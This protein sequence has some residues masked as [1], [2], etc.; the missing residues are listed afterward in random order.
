MDGDFAWAL[1]PDTPDKNFI[2][3]CTCPIV[4]P[5]YFQIIVYIVY[6]PYEFDSNR[7]QRDANIKIDTR[8]GNRKNIRL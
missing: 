1:D 7:T 6:V 4:R 5:S 8:D 3:G 2:K